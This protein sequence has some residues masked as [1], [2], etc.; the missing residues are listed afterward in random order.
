MKTAETT[1][2]WPERDELSL[3]EF[4]ALLE[5]RLHW[6]DLSERQFTEGCEYAARS[7]LA[8]ILCRPEQVSLAAK[9]ILGSPTKI[10]TGLGFHDPKAPELPIDALTAEAVELVGRGADEVSLL[11]APGVLPRCTEALLM[12][13][14]SAVHDA[15]APQGATVRVALN[16]EGLAEHQAVNLCSRLTQTG[17]AVVQAG[18]IRTGDRAPFS[19]VE[20]MRAALPRPTVLKWSYPVKSLEVVLVCVGLGVDRF[21]CDPREL[22]RAAKQSTRVGPLTV[23]A[24]GIDY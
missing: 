17:V 4:A 13:Q 6:P 3:S 23:P 15:V 11:A 21:D 1:A 12:D 16:C 20:A 22:L 8:A 5:H 14:L 9:A 10:V 24:P 19:W 7:G 2:L 18:A